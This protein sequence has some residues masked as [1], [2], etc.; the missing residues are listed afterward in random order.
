[1]DANLIVSILS[2]AVRSGTSVLL[3]VLGIIMSERTG[4][5]NLGVEGMMLIAALAS[6]AGAYYSGNVL[7][8]V[9]SG[10]LAGGVIALLHAFWCVT[11]RTNQ[12]ATG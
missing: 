11:L 9:L 5:L 4:V 3:A 8:G 1:M 12:V 7:I 10:A 2:I 6:F